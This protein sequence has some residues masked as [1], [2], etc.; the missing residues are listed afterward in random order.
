MPANARV[1]GGVSD[2]PR[3]SQSARKCLK[4]PESVNECPRVSKSA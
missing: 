4:V 3:V 1:S 2:C